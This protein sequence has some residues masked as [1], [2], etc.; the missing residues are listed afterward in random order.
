VSEE[1]GI[2]TNVLVRNFSYPLAKIS[3]FLFFVKK[4]YVFLRR[5]SG[6][7]GT[8]AS[9]AGKPATPDLSKETP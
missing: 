5:F 3:H 8:L 4:S 2:V 1:I 7:R 9:S 6:K